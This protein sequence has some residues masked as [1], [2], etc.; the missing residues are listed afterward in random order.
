[1]SQ[2]AA[3]T[4]SYVVPPHVPERLVVDFDIYN[5]PPHQGDYHLAL[6]QLHDPA[7]PEIFWS[8]RNGGHWIATRG[9]DIYHIFRQYEDFS[10]TRLQPLFR[11]ED[12]QLPPIMFDPPQHTEFRNLIT[13]VLTPKAVEGLGERAR[14]NAIALIE[15]FYPRGECEF[16]GEFAQQLPIG[17]FMNMVDLPATDRKMLLSWAE[18]QVRPTARDER[19]HGMDELF[20]YARAKIAERRAKPGK[21]LIST[22][23]QA[24]P[25]GKPLSDFHL[26][27]LVVMLLIGGLDT[28]ASMMGFVGK[29][30][31]TN[32][33]HRKQLIEKPELIG[34][35]ADEFMRRF[36]IV[37]QGRTVTHDFEYKGVQ[38]KKGDMIM[39][40]TALHGLDDRKFDHPLEVNFNR[41][42]PIH[43]TFGNGPH[44]CPGSY[45]ARVELRVF[46]EEWLK[47]IPDFC[48]KPGESAGFRA[49]VNAT[50]TYLPLAWDVGA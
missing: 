20:K 10:S 39:M 41:P 46:M 35:A 36:P 42:T 33:G 45:L 4:Q 16:I 25:N 7:V 26:E 6:K 40:P 11:D 1:M 23:S 13:P 44:R 27:S 21:D 49:G 50:V 18:Q 17:I 34:K 43:S 22:L 32:P 15:G 3:M 28:V 14:E 37:N 24:R 19:D 5:V 38:M 48:I 8:P 47:R 12:L 31:A 29:F 2:A 9:D 30:L